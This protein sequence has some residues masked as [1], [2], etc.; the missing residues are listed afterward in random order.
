MKRCE[1]QQ[2]ICHP[3]Y[4]HLPFHQY[5]VYTKLVLRIVLHLN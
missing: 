5:T 4:E 2:K 1:G 3:K